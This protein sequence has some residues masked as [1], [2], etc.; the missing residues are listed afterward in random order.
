MEPTHH[1]EK[2][3]DSVYFSF[4]IIAVT[5]DICD[6][7]CALETAGNALNGRSFI[8]QLQ[9]KDQPEVSAYDVGF[10]AVAKGKLGS[11]TG[12]GHAPSL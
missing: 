1:R 5:Y 11:G 12:K 7:L 3:Y 8:Y 2:P 9:F 6:S 4:I 10:H